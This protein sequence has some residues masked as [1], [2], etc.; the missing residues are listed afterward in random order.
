MNRQNLKFEGT[1]THYCK[2]CNTWGIPG[3]GTYKCGNCGLVGC[4]IENPFPDNLIPFVELKAEWDRSQTKVPNE[5]PT[6]QIASPKPPKGD[7]VE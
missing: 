3:Q 5:P 6:S 7:K 2:Y 4:L 1:A